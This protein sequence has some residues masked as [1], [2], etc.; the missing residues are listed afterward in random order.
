MQG[1]A[2]NPALR[3]AASGQRIAT[4]IARGGALALVG[5]GALVL[6]GWTLD[7]PELTCFG[8]ALGSMKANTAI[9]FVLLGVALE[10]RLA[11][12][13]SRLVRALAGLATAIGALSLGEWLFGWQLGIDELVF[14]DRLATPGPPGRMAPNTATSVVALGLAVVMIDAR[15]QARV[16]PAEM[17][18]LTACLI[19]FL[20]LL[21]YLYGADRLHT[22]S[23]HS[24]MAWHTALGFLVAG[25][26]VLAARSDGGIM[27]I[28]THEGPGGA[29][30]RRLSPAIV[31]VPVVFAWL[32]LAGERRG[33]F[34]REFGVAIVVTANVVCFLSLAVWTARALEK[35]DAASRSAERRFARLSEV[36]LIGVIV[37]DNQRKVLEMNDAFLTMIGRT[38]EEALSGKLTSDEVNFPEWRGIDERIGKDLATK[39]AAGL[40]EKEYRHRDGSRV[41][42]LVGAAMVDDKTCVAC[43]LDLRDK[44]RAEEALR[45]TEVQL[46]QAQKME[47]VGRLAG[48]IAHDFNNILSVILSYAEMLQ[49]ELKTHDPMRGE[50]EQIVKAGN[51]AAGLTRQLLAVGR[52]Q[53]LSPRVLDLNDLVRSF[54]AMVERVLGEDIEIAVRLQ[55]RARVLV[56]PGQMEQVL[57][58]L[59]VNA[60]DAMPKG[61]KLSIETADVEFDAAYAQKHVDVKPGPY[62]ML[63]VSDNGEG[64]D[65]AT[66]TRIFEPFFTTKAQGKGTG[67]GLPTVFGIVKQS[68]GHV[69]V[70]SEPKRGTTFKV[71]LP[72]TLQVSS[73]RPP[74]VSGRTLR[75]SETILLVED[76]EQVR[77]VTKRILTQSGYRVLDAASGPAAVALSEGFSGTIDLLLTDVVMPKMSGR[78]LAERLATRAPPMKV[79][80]MSGY[81]DDAVVRHGVLNSGVEFLQKPIMMDVLLGRVR[82]VLDTPNSELTPSAAATRERT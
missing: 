14:V 12:A 19:S 35:A 47:A 24:A 45:V 80:F 77:A 44:R 22:V 54:E 49:A 34:D 61:G 40:Y 41:P 31:G 50:L 46:H 4:R 30:L 18:A 6:A 74:V 56:D 33:L 72:Q 1:G 66:Q 28:V 71:Y 67:L 32:R 9:V 5:L 16:R 70:Y 81:T 11:G 37:V 52:R 68:G 59:V 69:W 73:S 60:R 42:A 21:G 36:G 64:M 53:V 75:G 48:G 2:A 29:L 10:R 76:E 17:L 27:S 15:P 62:V 20:A 58:N 65:A 79:I 38:R 55:S 3:S 23:A 7:V 39:G 8:T 26:T 63:S 43:V 13:D 25:T 51:R 78:E 82:D 57:L